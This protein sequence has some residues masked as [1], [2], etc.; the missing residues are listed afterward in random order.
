M[1]LI[2][3]LTLG[4]LLCNSVSATSLDNGPQPKFQ[5]DN[6]NTGQS[7]Y[8]GPKANGT[9]WKYGVGSIIT[10]PTIDSSG[11]IYIGSSDVLYAINPNG[12]QK[13]KYNIDNTYITTTPAIGSDRTIY[14]GSHE[15]IF[16]ALNPNGTQKWNY[17][18]GGAIQSS[19]AIGNDGTIYFGCNDYNFYA[20]NPNGTL[21]WEY[22]TGYAIRMSPAISSD[23][24]IYFQSAGS[25]GNFYGLNP[26]GTLKWKYH[27]GCFGSISPAIGS[28]GTIYCDGNE[29]LYALNPNGTLKWEYII[30]GDTSNIQMSPAIGKDGT[31]YY[32]SGL[33]SGGSYVLA[34]NPN[35]TLKWKYNA[36]L[37]STSGM[38][39][40]SDGY[41]YFGVGPSLVAL[42]PNGILKW[43]YSIDTESSSFLGVAIGSDGT[44]YATG[45]PSAYLYAFAD[46]VV[47]ASKK[48]GFYNNQVMVTLT[49][50]DPGPIYYYTTE[51]NIPTRYTLPILITSSTILKYFAL[52]DSNNPSPIYIQTYNIDKKAP[53]ASATPTGGYY[54]VF[55]TITLKMSEA[56]TIYYTLNGTTPSTKSS[57]YTKPL[58]ISTSKTL[59][60]FALDLAGNKSPVYTQK[61]IIAPKIVSTKPSNLKTGVS[62]TSMIAI[63]FTENIKASTYYNSIKLKN[64]STGKYVT[65]A[66]TISGSY[67]TIKTAT[68]NANTWYQVTI[69]AKAIKDYA[70]N[71]LL[72]TYTFKFKTGK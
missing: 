21:K 20:L 65:I 38:V 6:K 67:L 13:W 66:K 58:I 55:K 17:T 41:I 48:G 2:L 43:N 32:G 37:H 1:I 23:G 53:T 35:G 10:A 71:N 7:Q 11:T 27:T 33:S 29:G 4:I 49:T 12:T 5:H 57:K 54:N 64:L 15:G 9:K 68:K 22:T 61:Y 34:L 24:T 42:N 40:G 28:D 36:Q 70:G 47:S 45:S 56:G 60:Y 18:T 14:F 72:A 44:L 19:P 39:I 25:D 46:I 31:I 63:K 62:R 59:K 3:T 69:P 26:N 8:N 52:D 50:N 16:Y 51:G 30:E